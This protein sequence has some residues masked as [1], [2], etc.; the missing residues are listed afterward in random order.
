MQIN[1]LLLVVN[2]KNCI[3]VVACLSLICFFHVCQV[4]FLLS[5]DGG[6]SPWQP[7]LHRVHFIVLPDS[8]LQIAIMPIV[9][10]RLSVA[11]C[12]GWQPGAVSVL[13]A[14]GVADI[15]RSVRRG[16]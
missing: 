11:L 4:E 8:I 14:S 1:E 6:L 5:S 7:L 2:S 16:W 15:V 3:F 9:E 13:T 10:L 12:F